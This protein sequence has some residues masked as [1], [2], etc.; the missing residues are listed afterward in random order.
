M[1]RAGRIV[2]AITAICLLT[3]GCR[4][5]GEEQQRKAQETRE[6]LVLWT[7][8]ETEQQKEAL[9]ELTEGFNASQDQYLLRWEYHGPLT[10]FNK[11]MAIGITQKQLP[12]IVILDNPDMR[13]YVEQG[14]LEDLTMEIAKIENLDNYYPNVM[15]SV[16]YNDRYYGIPFCSNNVALIYNEDVFLEKGLSV[17]ENW[18][19]FLEC[20]AVLTEGE[21]KGFAMSAIEGEQSAFQILPFILSAGDEINQLGGQGTREAFALVRQLVDMGYVSKECINWSQNDVARKFVD[22][23]CAMMENGPWVLPALEEAGVPYKIAELPYKLQP[24]GVMGGENLGVM[25]GKNADGAVAFMKYYNQE[26]QMLKTNIRANALPPRKDVAQKMLEVCPEYEIFA[27]Q[28]E[29][30]IGRT[31]CENW[32]QVTELLSKAQFEII[33]GRITPEEAVD[34]IREQGGEFS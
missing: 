32:L 25:K 15:D 34:L 31:S 30:C 26:E 27:K 23:E 4:Q 12:D 29:T 13:R 17:P 10:E 16:R 22:G 8:Y 18:E 11:K 7:Y 3:G 24:A 33:T 19:E 9:Q 2:T 1:K 14:V 6:E 28:M 5:T 20:A 21:R